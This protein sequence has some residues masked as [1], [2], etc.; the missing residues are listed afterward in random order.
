MESYNGYIILSFFNFKLSTTLCITQIYL[1]HDPNTKKQVTNYFK[2]LILLNSS[3]NIPHIIMGD[4][5]SVPDPLIDKLHNNFPSQKNPIYNYL[6]LY[7]DSFRH[8]HPIQLNLL[9][10]VLP[11]KVKSTRFGYRI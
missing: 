5:N 8:L 11:N 2:D 6:A 1:P 10:L 9:I 3:K 7:I 4:F